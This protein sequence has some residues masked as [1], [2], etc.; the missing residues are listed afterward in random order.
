MVAE[1]RGKP[2]S[3]LR[4]LVRGI[5]DCSGSQLHLGRF[6]NGNP[7]CMRMTVGTPS[8]MRKRLPGL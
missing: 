3:D 7:T 4:M 6:G 5:G 1:A 2:A 8:R